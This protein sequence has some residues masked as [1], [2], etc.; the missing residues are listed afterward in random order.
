MSS[1][2]MR[3]G[4]YIPKEL[5]EEITRIMNEIGID[6]VS[7][8]VQEGLR[9]YI[10]EYRWRT[11]GDVVGAIGIIYDHEVGHVDEE[12]TDL[13]HKYIDIIV[14]SLHIHL[15]LRN[16]LIIIIVRGLSKTIKK[17]LEDIEK[18]RGVKMVRLML[19]SR[20]L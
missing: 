5:A 8:V 15:D 6:S 2:P 16:C 7:K 11:E 18:I 1:K 13:Q 4:V 3:I 20:Q 14:S 12:L 9:L 19:M 17:F 10:A